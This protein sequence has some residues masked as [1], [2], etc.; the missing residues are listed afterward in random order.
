MP[1]YEFK[2]NETE[3]VFEALMSISDKEE[4]LKDNPNITQILSGINIVAGVGGIRND[5]GWNENLQRI[6]EA[7]P[8]SD[9][10]K[11]YGSKDPKTVS[12]RNAV[13]RWRKATGRD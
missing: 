4:F 5:E 11:R 9:L 2:D 1:N 12:T 13:D 8:A 6:A 7:H 3:E 10:A